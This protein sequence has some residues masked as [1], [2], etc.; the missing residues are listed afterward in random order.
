MTAPVVNT[1][2]V[3][4]T[5]ITHE[6][7][8]G[9]NDYVNESNPADHSSANVTY[10][11]PFT[12]S[13]ATNVE[14]KLAQTVSVKDFGA[15]GDGVTDDSVAFVNAVASGKS[16]YIPK[17]TYIVN[18]SL[19][20][21]KGQNFYGEGRNLVT[22]QVPDAFSDAVVVIQQGCAV[23]DLT[24]T[25]PTVGTYNSNGTAVQVSNTVVDPWNTSIRNLT[26]NNFNVGININNYRHYIENVMF[27]YCNLGAVV[28]YDTSKPAGTT[29]FNNCAFLYNGVAGLW[30]RS[31]ATHTK[32]TAST[33][34]ISNKHIVCDGVLYV[35]SCYISDNG[36]WNVTGAGRIYIENGHVTPFES[37]AIADGANWGYNF[38]TT[39]DEYNVIVANALIK[40][41]TLGITYQFNNGSGRRGSVLGPGQ[42]TLV[43]CYIS[44]RSTT[45]NS[46]YS[47]EYSSTIDQQILPSSTNLPNYVTNG[48]FTNRSAVISGF[49][50]T[51]SRNVWGG[52]IKTIA[53]GSYAD[54]DFTIP[55]D[56]D[57]NDP[58]ILMVYVGYTTGA[59][60]VNLTSS[61]NIT[62]D[63]TNYQDYIGYASRSSANVYVLN[64]GLTY[65][66]K[67]SVA[68]NSIIVKATSTTGT[69][70]I[71][72]ISA[73]TPI[74]GVV[75]TPIN[76]GM[77]GRPI[78]WFYNP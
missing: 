51:G 20:L 58:L 14:A 21:A 30:V 50:S 45:Y 65:G 68:L 33:F 67:T 22:I 29:Q 17:G 46:M 77:L 49:T 12:D 23:F 72:N 75:L 61:T 11:P 1:V 15:V 19:V 53:A 39:D 47:F 26:I 69:I 9:V 54:I 41:V 3:P 73:T 64:K 44:N 52:D 28:G 16:V 70:R 13:V 18:V 40:D 35:D 31:T 48:T 78:G 71:T 74:H 6:W 63:T 5:T 8:N 25:R 24:F 76:A 2:F 43:N 38:K 57:L 36:A 10:D 42:Y 56:W 27:F 59:A 60:T 37:G 32:V 4:G 55:S 34:E 7:L 62:E 66:L